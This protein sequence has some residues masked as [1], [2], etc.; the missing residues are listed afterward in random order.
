[1]TLAFIGRNLSLLFVFL[2]L[3]GCTPPQ[4]II[5]VGLSSRPYTAFI[6][7]ANEQGFFDNGKLVLHQLPSPTE[8]MQAF[9]AGKIDVALI[10]IDQVVTLAEQS[11]DFKIISVIDKSVGGLALLSSKNLDSI[12]KLKGATIGLERIS[13]GAILFN[14][15][16]MQH[17]DIFGSVKLVEVRSNMGLDIFKLKGLDAVIAGSPTKQQLISAGANELYNSKNMQQSILH[18]MVAR[19]ETI[20][21]NH[22]DLSNLLAG[23]YKAQHYFISNQTSSREVLKSKLDVSTKQLAMALNDFEFMDKQQALIN[24]SGAPS[25]VELELINMSEYMYA[26]KMLTQ[27][28]Q[29]NFSELIDASLLKGMLND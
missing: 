17:P 20:A 6:Q 11:V 10:S 15:L 3:W 29:V 23:F 28:Y 8:T 21:G 19:T 18:F 13:S 1:M 26:N 27:S 22:Q 5:K 4:D 24:L 12:Q 14:E 7:L 25:K 16:L 2:S 9:Q